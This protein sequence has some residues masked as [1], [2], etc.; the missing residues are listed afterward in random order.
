MV[1]TYYLFRCPVCSGNIYL[2]EYN[3]QKIPEPG[4][5]KLPLDANHLQMHTPIGWFQS[6]PQC[7]KYFHNTGVAVRDI[8]EVI[9]PEELECGYYILNGIE[10]DLQKGLLVRKKNTPSFWCLI[11]D[12]HLK[13]IWIAPSRFQMFLA[14]SNV[15]N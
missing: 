9:L 14:I 6:T 1:H 5:L 4:E 15:T 2:L 7:W 11:I 12:D 10:L 13:M 3:D 8:E